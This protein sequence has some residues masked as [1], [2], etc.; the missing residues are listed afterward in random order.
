MEE[1]LIEELDEKEIYWI[2]FYNSQKE[3]YNLIPG[4]QG[5]RGEANPG[6]KLT[7]DEVKDII[8]KLKNTTISIQ[9]LAKEYNVHYNTISDIN[10]CRTWNWLHN[11]K[12]NIRLEV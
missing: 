4:G 9:N 10:C 6:A 3:G 1:C 12:K 5:Y 2:N 8:E 11:Y 7:E